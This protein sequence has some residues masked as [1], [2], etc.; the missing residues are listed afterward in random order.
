MLN[1]IRDTV[2]PENKCDKY[3]LGEKNERKNESN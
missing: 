3:I 2:L 1:Y